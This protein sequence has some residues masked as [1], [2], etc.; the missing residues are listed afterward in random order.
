MEFQ[1]ITISLEIN[2]Y[3]E[4]VW[5]CY[6]NPEHIVNWNFA[7]ES[8]C[9]PSA[10]N[11]LT[12]GGKYFARMEARDGSFGFDFEAI[13]LDVQPTTSFTY[14]LADERIVKV[15]FEAKDNSTTVT[16]VFDAET[17]NPIEVQEGGWMAI[18][19]NFKAYVEKN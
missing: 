5:D 16:I 9:C 6:T 19:Q 4:K 3:K 10:S 15:D 7:H 18:L 8:W 1:K 2:A 11:D 12:V 17:E 13:Y 14:Q